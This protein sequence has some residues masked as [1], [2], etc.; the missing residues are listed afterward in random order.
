M[1]YGD[2]EALFIQTLSP[3]VSCRSIFRSVADEG[4]T[5]RV[6][7]RG[8]ERDACSIPVPVPPH[9]QPAPRSFL[10]SSDITMM[11]LSCCTQGCPRK[12]V[13]V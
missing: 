1:Y 10:P 3:H 4:T 13:S 2:K 5:R 6:L 12:E 11:Y 8:R 9:L 7:A